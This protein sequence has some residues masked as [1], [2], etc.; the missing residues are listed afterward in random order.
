MSQRCRFILFCCLWGFA[1]TNGDDATRLSLVLLVSCYKGCRRYAPF[2]EVVS[3]A[4]TNGV[5]ATRLSL[6]LLVSCYKGCR[7]YAPFGEVVSAAVTNGVG[8]TRLSLVF[9]GQLL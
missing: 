4:V 5:G 9:V 1:I 7:R 2:G 3:A 8:A 6:V